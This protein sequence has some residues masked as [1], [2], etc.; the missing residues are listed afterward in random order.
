[1][2]GPKV[3][4]NPPRNRPNPVQYHR[5]D[6]TDKEVLDGGQ[7]LVGTSEIK[8]FQINRPKISMKIV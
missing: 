6:I 5:A 4:L 2:N 7:G 1:V 3:Y 8:E